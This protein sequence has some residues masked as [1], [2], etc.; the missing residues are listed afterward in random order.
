MDA[1]SQS[2]FEFGRFRV[3]PRSRELSVAGKPIELGGRAFDVLLTLIEARGSVVSKDELMARVWP[4][5]V[6]E[7]NNL[8]VQIATLGKV[9]ADDRELIR[10]VAGLGYQFH[11]EHLMVSMG[12]S[13]AAPPATNLTAP[14]LEL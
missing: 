10:T 1:D 6:V 3:S 14:G 8:Q 7:E 9:M 5:R 13:K 12:D 11:Y 2:A 4:G